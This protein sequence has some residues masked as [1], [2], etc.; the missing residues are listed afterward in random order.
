MADNVESA[1]FF[2]Y[3]AWS[4]S[5]RYFAFATGPLYGT[6]QTVIWDTV[7]Q[8]I[9]G[10]FQ[11]TFSKVG[12]L[13]WSDTDNYLIVGTIAG[14]YLW[15][16]PSNE[17]IEISR[18]NGWF[19]SLWDT[20]HQQVFF[21]D[22]RYILAYNL[23]TGGLIRKF[24]SPFSWSSTQFNVSP[25]GT[26]LTIYDRGSYLWSVTWDINAGKIVDAQAL[27][28]RTQDEVQFSPDRRF[29]LIYDYG[30]LNIYD[31][32]VAEKLVTDPCWP[33]TSINIDKQSWH[34]E[35]ASTIGISYK[36]TQYQYDMAAHTLSPAGWA[37]FTIQ[38]LCD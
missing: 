16:L 31:T 32:T 6:E 8:S 18:D 25:D 9:A 1:T 27:G 37:P 13:E 11:H 3:G 36:G 29:L 5:C 34:F 15:K 22:G 7:Q 26:T 33:S 12:W 35:N 28:I 19:N 38:Q 2:R 30:G 20:P 10:K 4:P 23:N 24:I 17:Q 21:Y 14:S